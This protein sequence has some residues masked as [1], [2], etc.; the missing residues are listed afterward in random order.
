VELVGFSDNS[1]WLASST[2]NEI[3]LWDFT[4]KGPEG[5]RPLVLSGHTDR[6]ASFAWQPGGEHFVS[7]GRDWRLNLWRPGKT[8][9]P[10]DV[11]LQDSDITAIRWSSDGKRVAVG[12]RNGRITL[13]DLVS[14]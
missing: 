1:R 8:P 13:F 3:V 7:G 9:Q 14:R 5:T 4:G 6:V 11:Q 12:E 2:G 10:L